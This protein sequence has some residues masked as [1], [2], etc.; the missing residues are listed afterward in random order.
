MNRLLEL[1]SFLKGGEAET[2][3]GVTVEYM[4]GTKGTMTIYEN[5]TMKEQVELMNIKK[6]HEIHELMESKG[7]VKKSPEECEE[8]LAAGYRNLFDERERKRPKQEYQRKKRELI[9]A[10]RRD[11]MLEEANAIANKQTPYRRVLQHL[12]D[13]FHKNNA[14]ERFFMTGEGSPRSL[15]SK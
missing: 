10:F 4:K 3:Q 1:K 13:A 15:F 8:I 9:Q 12:E 7:F 11:V 2:Y 5:G 14:A 6:K